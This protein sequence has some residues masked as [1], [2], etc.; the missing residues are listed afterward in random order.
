M[1]DNRTIILGIESSCDDTSA[2]V[3]ADGLLLSGVY[4]LYNFEPQIVN[5]INLKAV[6]IVFGAVLVFGIVITSTCTML[7]INKYLRMKSKDLYYM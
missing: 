1:S 5:I 6:A 3:I 4:W 7:S 2:A